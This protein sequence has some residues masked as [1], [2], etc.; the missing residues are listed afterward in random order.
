MEGF[1]ICLKLDIGE[2]K[3]CSATVGPQQRIMT[4]EEKKV[5]GTEEGDNMIRSKTTLSK[6][7]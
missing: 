5:Q 7:I 3:K 2:G 4:R 1:N 6:I